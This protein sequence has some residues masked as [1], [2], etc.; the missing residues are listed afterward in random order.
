MS[1][2]TPTEL[3][4]TLITLLAG[5]TE[6]KAVSWEG[7]VGLVEVLPIAF[8]P[9]CNWRVEVGGAA[10]DQEVIDEAVELLRDAHPCVS[11]ERSP[12]G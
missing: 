12:G 1:A 10:G 11:A 5:V 2:P 7:L 4:A 6:T 3:R 8:N 9:R